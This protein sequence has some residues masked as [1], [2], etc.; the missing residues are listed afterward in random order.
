MTQLDIRMKL[1]LRIKELRADKDVSQ[2][3]LAYKI[4]MSRTYLAE[5]EI[6]KRNISAVNLE[7]I[8]NGLGVSLRSFFDSKLFSST[9]TSAEEA[10]APEDAK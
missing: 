10:L 7:R 4:G 1:G 5:A 2:E 3:W 6:G 9:S 8:A